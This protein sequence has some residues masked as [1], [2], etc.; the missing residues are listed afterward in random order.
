MNKASCKGTEL[1]HYDSV[2]SLLHP[3][4]ALLL[5]PVWS[6]TGPVTSPLTYILIYSS[7]LSIPYTH[8]PPHTVFLRVSLNPQPAVHCHPSTGSVPP[9]HFSVHDT[10]HSSWTSWSLKMEAFHFS[11]M[12]VTVYICTWCHIQIVV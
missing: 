12:L 10:C 1:E 11:G 5:I 4:F 8:P 9:L 6:V 7:P 2:H 3:E